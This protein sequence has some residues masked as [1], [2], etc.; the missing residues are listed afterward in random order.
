MKIARPVIK[1]LFVWKEP[2]REL[3]G[4]EATRLA[5]R[6]SSNYSIRFPLALGKRYVLE[7]GRE[8]S[9]RVLL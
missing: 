8:R 9:C 3:W 1:I 7:S 4:I 5:S 6:P 2:F